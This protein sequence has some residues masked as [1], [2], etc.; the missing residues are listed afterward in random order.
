[1]QLND[2]K[3]LNSWI[4]TLAIIS[5][6]LTSQ[7]LPRWMFWV[8]DLWEQGAVG[9]GRAHALRGL[10]VGTQLPGVEVGC[11]ETCFPCCWNWRC[12]LQHGAHPYYY[13]ECW[14]SVSPTSVPGE[15]HR[16]SPARCTRHAITL[17]VSISALISGWWGGNIWIRSSARFLSERLLPKVNFIVFL[18]SPKP[19]IKWQY[20]FYS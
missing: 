2:H 16:C 8:R 10:V 4:C 20:Q 14:E 7:L 9:R 11:R 3:R 12:C 1:M 6:L 15:S 5:Y 19:I 13:A 17:P 18:C